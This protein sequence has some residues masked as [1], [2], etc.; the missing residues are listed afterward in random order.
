MKSSTIPATGVEEAGET[1]PRRSPSPVLTPAACPLDLSGEKAAPCPYRQQGLDHG[2][3]VG[4]ASVIR[5]CCEVGEGFQRRRLGEMRRWCAMR[6]VE[7]EK[8]ACVLGL[9]WR[10]V[11][12]AS[13]LKQRLDLTSGPVGLGY[14]VRTGPMF[15]RAANSLSWALE[16]RKALYIICI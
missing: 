14:I 7:A 2:S 9:D 1:G 3:A 8:T 12:D 16:S 13:R 5:S 6:R 10:S 15:S 4:A 11:G